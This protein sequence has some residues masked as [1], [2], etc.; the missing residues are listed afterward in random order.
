MW[1]RKT[2]CRSWWT[3]KRAQIS[4]EKPSTRENSHTIRLTPGS[5]V[6]ST[7]DLR[8]GARRKEKK[9]TGDRCILWDIAVLYRPGAGSWWAWQGSN[10]HLA[11]WARSSVVE[12]WA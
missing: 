5:P 11:A 12:L 3:T 10:L 1:Q 4:L 6:N 2:V 8:E 7:D 9:T